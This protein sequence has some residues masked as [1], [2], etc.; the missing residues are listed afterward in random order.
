MIPVSVIII[1]KNEADVIAKCI[2]TC[3]AIT[4][5]IIIIDNG[6]ADNTFTIAEGLGCKVY[7]ETWDGYG[8]NKN[9]GAKYAKYDWILSIDADELPDAELIRS[10]HQLTFD[11][12]K[13]A[14]DIKF[15]SYLGVKEIR[16]GN[17]GNDHR[18]RLFNRNFVKWSSQK[19]HETLLVPADIKIKRLK[20][21]IH[22]YTVNNLEECH[23]KA[24]YY[25]NLSAEQYLIN[26]KKIAIIKFYF[27]PIFGFVRNYIVRFGFL[28]GVAGLK[29][30]LIIYKNTWL[31]YYYLKQLQRNLVQMTSKDHVVNR[32]DMEYKVN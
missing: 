11:E 2:Q 8:A 3:R 13:T 1:T 20:G 28:D 18:I 16:H 22:H 19:V 23:Q 6:S 15:K 27:S 26:N 31:K 21:N 12:P 10:L 17:W 9:K 4:E 14:F 5:D 29:I 7:L 24:I 25:A 30:A 32:L